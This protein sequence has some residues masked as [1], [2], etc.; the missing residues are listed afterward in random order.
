MVNLWLFLLLACSYRGR[1][2]GKRMVKK[3]EMK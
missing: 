2:M 1:V 3:K